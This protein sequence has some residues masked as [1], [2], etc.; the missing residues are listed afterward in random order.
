MRTFSKAYSHVNQTQL[1]LISG[2][3]YPLE[4]EVAINPNMTE[5]PAR[6]NSSVEWVFFEFL[7]VSFM[8]PVITTAMEK[9]GVKSHTHDPPEG[10]SPFAVV[11]RR[12][13]SVGE[14]V[15]DK[16]TG[17]LSP[18]ANCQGGGVGWEVVRR[19][20]RPKLSPP[21]FAGGQ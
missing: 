13:P 7:F 4:D 21:K 2:L 5:S 8:H 17:K 18:P 6:P 20:V 3:A 11:V 10:V 19:P 15:G 12:R 14:G 9:L 1:F 16:G